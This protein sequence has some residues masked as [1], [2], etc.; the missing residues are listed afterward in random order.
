MLKLAQADDYN[1][2]IRMARN[3]HRVSPYS[4]LGFS[5]D[6]VGE[7]FRHYLRG[8]KTEIIF[9]LACNPHPVGMIVGY[10]NKTPFS[11][12]KVASEL[13]WWVD[14]EY[15]RSK[16]SI[17]LFKAYEDWALRVGCSLSQMAM[18]DE[19][20]DLS[21]FY[22]KQGYIPAEKSYIKYL[23]ENA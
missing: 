23:K 18:L 9:I 20:T 5:E 15:R 4:V 7:M 2:V 10:A 13:A 11:D 6:K 14:E 3:F 8:D 12:T 22:E 21:A 17:L 1:H 16:G 19:V